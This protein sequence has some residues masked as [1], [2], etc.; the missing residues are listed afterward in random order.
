MSTPGITDAP[1]FKFQS[2]G[3]TRIAYY[4][5]TYSA[6]VI[7]QLVCKYG[8]TT[9]YG[10]GYVEA[11]NVD[12]DAGGPYNAVFVRVKNCPGP[13]LAQPG[14]SGGPVFNGN[15]VIGH[16]NFEDDGDIFCPWKMVFNSVTHIQTALGVTV[17]LTPP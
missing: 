3:A 2:S 11:K 14:D 5:Q 15:T 8:R 13:D 4:L 7:N 10:C 12:P 1:K 16:V 9:G 17:I 6:I